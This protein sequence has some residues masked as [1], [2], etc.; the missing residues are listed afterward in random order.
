[1]FHTLEKRLK[2]SIDIEHFNSD[3]LKTLH[4]Y[5]DSNGYNNAATLL[6]DVNDFPGTDIVKFVEP[7]HPTLCLEDGDSGNTGSLDFYL[8]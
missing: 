3:T 1:M 4:L 7:L 6:A 8:L 2:D 5:S